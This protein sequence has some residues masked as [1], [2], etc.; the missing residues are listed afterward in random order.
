[1]NYESIKWKRFFN[2]DIPQPKTQAAKKIADGDAKPKR[3][4][5]KERK[6][7]V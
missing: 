3:A 4:K 6:G 7:D 1:M 5:S 2:M